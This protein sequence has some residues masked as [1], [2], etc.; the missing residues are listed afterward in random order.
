M[1]WKLFYHTYEGQDRLKHA[2]RRDIFHGSYDWPRQPQKQPFNLDGCINTLSDCMTEWKVS[3]AHVRDPS[4][5]DPD[6]GNRPKMAVSWDH[7][8]QMRRADKKT[9]I[10]ILSIQIRS[11]IRTH[12]RFRLQAKSEGQKLA[13]ICKQ[14]CVPGPGGFDQSGFNKSSWLHANVTLCM[15][16]GEATQGPGLIRG[17]LINGRLKRPPVNGAQLIGSSS[18]NPH[19]YQLFPPYSSVSLMN[20]SIIQW[21]LSIF[22]FRFMCRGDGSLC[23][24][25]FAWTFFYSS[26]LILFLQTHLVST[27]SFPSHLSLS[28]VLEGELWEAKRLIFWHSLYLLHR[29]HCYSRHA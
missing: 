27:V 15:W 17:K 26:V 22:P 13:V 14:M 7:Q 10:S 5:L 28:S 23:V 9:I 4:G 21:I 1:T 3:D 18:S 2:W 19:W 16:M 20:R 29:S 12:R 6:S 8:N 25:C 11:T 24:A